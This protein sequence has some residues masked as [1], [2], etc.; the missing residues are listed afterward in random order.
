[1]SSLSQAQ[2]PILSLNVRRTVD[3][4]IQMET[5][6]NQSVSVQSLAQPK[7]E[8]EDLPQ[9]DHSEETKAVHD[10]LEQQCFSFVA[11]HNHIKDARK[12]Q[13]KQ[14]QE[15]HSRAS[16]IENRLHF[17]SKSLFNKVHELNYRIDLIQKI[18]SPKPI[19]K[20]LMPQNEFGRITGMSIFNEYLAI[21]TASGNL[22]IMNKDNFQILQNLE[23]FQGESLFS[24][25][26]VRKSND[27]IGLFT[28]S[29]SRK[30]LFCYPILSSSGHTFGQKVECYALPDNYGKHQNFEIVTG[31]HQLINYS[32][33]TS[34]NLQENVGATSGLR[35][36]VIGL[37]V[38]D[39]NESVY[40]ITSKRY[41]Y[42]IST[43]NFQ[44]IMNKSFQMPLMQIAK[45]CIFIIVSCAPNDILLLER[46]RDK[47]NQLYKIEITTGLRRFFT[48]EKALYIINQNQQ[49]ERRKLCSPMVS[50]RICESENADYDPKEYIGALLCDDSNIYLTHGNRI[51]LWT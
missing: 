31:H 38:D 21:T 26:F 6:E 1:M 4:I 46:N 17:L 45:T 48:S 8:K 22:V 16:A 43:T 18:L 29:S 19:F 20:I 49:V 39:E 36:T 37:L 13:T 47:F 10:I 14:M 41:Y 32:I 30:L 35:G 34:D 33:I 44:V 51:S 25:L 27:T 9:Q 15:F 23:P 3:A 28:I 50:Q 11:F 40:A 5:D 24:P 7:K 42:S 2:P 12:I